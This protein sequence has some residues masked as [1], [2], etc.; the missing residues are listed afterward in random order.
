LG[1][2]RKTNKKN[3]DDLIRVKNPYR[4]KKYKKGRKGKKK[5]WFFG[6]SS[7][8]KEEEIKVPKVSVKM[9]EE[10]SSSNAENKTGVLEHNDDDFAQ[11]CLSCGGDTHDTLD[12]ATYKTRMCWYHARNMCRNGDRC[13]FVHDKN[14]IRESSLDDETFKEFPAMR[15]HR[16]KKGQ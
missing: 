2:L 16:T 13:S 4:Y 7:E 15:T 10:I 8:P 14:E 6:N 11:L 3:C 12:C 9:T 5:M 1:V